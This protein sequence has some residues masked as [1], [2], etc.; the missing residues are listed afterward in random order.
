M[1]VSEWFT[2]YMST[3]KPDLKPRTREEYNRLFARFC[4]PLSPLH[5]RAVTPEDIADTLAAA[6]SSGARTARAVYVL[7]RGLFARAVR[8]RQLQWSPVDALDPPPYHA[9]TGQSIPPA[10][11]E[12]LRPYIEA[13]PGLALALYAGMRRGEIAALRWS[14]IDL[15][16][17]LIHVSRSRER[18][19]GIVIETTPKSAAGCR[20]IPIAAPLLLILRRAYHL[21]SSRVVS[22][23]PEWLSKRFRAVQQLAG[24]RSR[25][26]LHDLRHTYITTLVAEGVPP[27]IVQ[28]CAGHSS[29]STTMHI[30]T[31]LTGISALRYLTL[32][33]GAQGSSP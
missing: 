30:Y 17:R 15:A 7:L 21:D 28:Y 14:D 19:C 31:H 27:A 13:E 3:Y 26:H 2:T 12:R 25:Y 18:V 22:H 10:D 5:L 32:N 8:S 6:R 20:D 11:L 24:I 16:A 1:T 33:Q 9:A 29:L 4:R 23:A